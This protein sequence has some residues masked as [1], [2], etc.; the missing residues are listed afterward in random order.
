MAQS[1][2]AKKPPVTPSEGT[3]SFSVEEPSSISEMPSVTRLLNRARFGI[4]D[5]TQTSSKAARPPSLAQ[6][7]VPPVA[8]PPVIETAPP[9]IAPIPETPRASA[10]PVPFTPPADAPALEVTHVPSEQPAAPEEIKIN[11]ISLATDTRFLATES[12]SS[13]SAAASATPPPSEVKEEG[14]AISLSL[15]GETSESPLPP[16]TAAEK[17]V[18]EKTTSEKNA[19]IRTSERALTR[20]MDYRPARI[21]NRDE[22]KFG[23]DPL[24][25]GMNAILESGKSK[26]MLFLQAKADSKRPTFESFAVSDVEE[27]RFA[28]LSGM[29]WDSLALPELWSAFIKAGVLEISPPSGPQKMTAQLQARL[30]ARRLFDASA[31]E[32]LTLVKIGSKMTTRGILVILSKGSVLNEVNSSSLEFH[33]EVPEHSLLF[34]VPKDSPPSGEALTLDLAA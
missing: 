15:E 30:L 33:S 3:S 24:G 6:E 20:T 4:G 13:T 8:S 11:E 28:W 14:I 12:A 10:S 16:E 9:V 32:T 19:G 34:E 2:P 23:Q 5:R 25:T 18:P 29:T 7:V 26:G 21:W 1:P 27:R 17:P 22:L 31:E